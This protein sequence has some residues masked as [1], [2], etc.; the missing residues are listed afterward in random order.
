M[1][2]WLS[3]M[4]KVSN[5]LRFV[6]FEV[7]FSIWTCLSGTDLTC[8]SE[9]TFHVAVI[10]VL[11]HIFSWIVTKL[12]V[13]IHLLLML[14]LI[15]IQNSTLILVESL[16]IFIWHLLLLLLHLLLHLLTSCNLRLHILVWELFLTH[17]STSDSIMCLFLVISIITLSFVNHFHVVLGISG[18]HSLLLLFIGGQGLTV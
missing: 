13:F 11:A 18:V 7:T 10:I 16:I 3:L 6:V 2:S 5:I 12:R 9:V 4:H 8:F 1:A 17:S 15:L 14:N